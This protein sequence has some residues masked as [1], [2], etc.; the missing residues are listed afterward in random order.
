ME[1]I[2]VTG[3]SGAG[4]S[5]AS[6]TL[7]DMGFYCVD[8][9]PPAIIPAFID[10]SDANG[11]FSK[12]ALITDIRGGELFKSIDEVLKGLDER[13]FEYKI[14]FLDASD[15][16]LIRRYKENRRTHPLNKNGKLS[17]ASA[18]EKERK[19]L[20]K[21]RSRADYIID[22]TNLLTREL[23]EEL[24]RIFILEKEYN[25]LMVSVMSFG[26]KYGI[27]AD[28][29][30]VFDVRFLPN[31]FYVEELRNQTGNDQPVVDYIC[32]YPQ[33]FEYLKLEAKRFDFL[34]P[35]YINEGKSQLVISVGC[36]GGQHRSVYIVD[37]LK[38]ALEA[39]WSIQV[40]HREMKHWS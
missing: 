14:L 21:I 18:V 32:R 39:K 23:K 24:E 4:K 22:T 37:R 15:E 40:L 35:Q 16:V 3:M 10:M 7:E 25:S 26:F 29:D 1:L 12:M 28:A 8:N 20:K 34:I 31:P 27:P 9:V 30:L 38:K 33:T 11:H 6:N 36:T 17:L 2:I 5:Q 13:N 19:A